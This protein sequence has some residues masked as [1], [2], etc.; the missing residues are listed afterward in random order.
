MVVADGV[1]AARDAAEAVAVEYEVLP[2]V[3][4]VLEALADGAPTLWPDAPDNL[5]L[6][7]AFGDRAA[8]EAALEKSHV[9][10][11]QTIRSQRTASAFMEPRSAIGSYDGAEQQYTLISGCQ[12]AHRLR[13]AIAGCRMWRG[14]VRVLCPDVAAPSD[15]ASISIRSRSR[16]YGGA[17]RRAAGEWTGDR[18]RRSHRPPARR[19]DER[20]AGARCKGCIA[21]ALELTATGAHRLLGRSVTA[22]AWRRRSTMPIAWVRL[23]ATMTNTVPTALLRRR[24]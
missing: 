11:E 24:R 8:V 7:N 1:T 12:G 16:S 6:D 20:A 23:R 3:T 4:D 10:I 2:A 22:T 14:C 13:H 21:L 5:A 17:P 9:V 18:Q 19:G 15:R